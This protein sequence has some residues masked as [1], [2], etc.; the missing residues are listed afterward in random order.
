MS[1]RQRRSAGDVDTA[2]LGS[3]AGETG[4]Q[5]CTEAD[6][7]ATG[8]P[9]PARG[10][11]AVGRR[12]A[13]PAAV[14]AP[15][16]TK[17]DPYLL[18]HVWSV[19]ASGAPTLADVGTFGGR[20][21]V[22]A[23]VRGVPVYLNV[24]SSRAALAAVRRRGGPWPDAVERHRQPEGSAQQGHLPCRRARA[25]L[26]LLHDRGAGRCRAPGWGGRRTL[27][28]RRRG[29]AIRAW[30]PQRRPTDRGER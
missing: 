20:A 28:A 8:G 16:G 29:A 21:V 19:L 18:A 13:G 12:S 3:R 17:D 11:S 22:W 26:L 5:M 30:P 14:P 9:V 7:A 27:S 25:R 23:T 24:D 15:R 2:V 1:R 4:D 10:S 6:R